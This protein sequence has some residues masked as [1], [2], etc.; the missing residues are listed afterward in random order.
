MQNSLVISQK[1]KHRTT[2]WLSNSTPHYISKR[3]KTWDCNRYLYTNVRI[4][5]IYTSYTIYII[6]NRCKQSV[7]QQMNG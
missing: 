4:N 1:V 5:I 7:Y 2:L 6:Y 3:T